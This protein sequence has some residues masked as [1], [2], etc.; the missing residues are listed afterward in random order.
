MCSKI[1]LR[2]YSFRELELEEKIGD[3]VAMIRLICEVKFKTKDGWSESYSAIVDTGAPISVIPFQIWTESEAEIMAEHKI[4]GVVPKEECTL[5]VLVGRIMCILVDGESF[6]EER[7]LLAYLA[8]T[9]EIPLILGFKDLLSV[10]ELSFFYPD[11]AWVK[12]KEI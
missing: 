6:S 1:K 11:Q 10:F 12:E 8:L 9:N 7:Q 3:S 2:F 4:R 5:P